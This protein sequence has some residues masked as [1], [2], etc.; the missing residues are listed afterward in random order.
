MKRIRIY[1][2]G[3]KEA[4]EILDDGGSLIKFS[5]GHAEVVG[6]TEIKKKWMGIYGTTTT[7]EGGCCEG[8]LTKRSVELLEEHM[9]SQK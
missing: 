4:Q 7:R 9:E 2:M 8:F 5:D 3:W 6:P 1:R